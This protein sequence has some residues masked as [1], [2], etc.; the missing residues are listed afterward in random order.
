M[1]NILYQN[2]NAIAFVVNPLVESSF[3]T[4]LIQQYPA[5]N[6]YSRAWTVSMLEEL[7]GTFSR[8]VLLIVIPVSLIL[9]IV[10]LVLQANQI[11]VNIDRLQSY[12]RYYFTGRIM[13]AYTIQTMGWFV[14]SLLLVMVFNII[15]DSVTGVLP[16]MWH[17]V[18]ID[19]ILM[20][21]PSCIYVVFRLQ[22]IR[23][24]ERCG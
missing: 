11:S 12:M 2:V 18:I 14:L 1:Y 3:L 22:K 13:K 15:Y 8:S 4:E 19:W 10:F 21:L 23:Y 6:Y 5:N 9:G 20:A 16:Y 24:N 7:N 17:L